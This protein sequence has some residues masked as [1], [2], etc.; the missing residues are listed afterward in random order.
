MARKEKYSIYVKPY[1]DKIVEWISEGENEYNI[2]NKL[3][4]C[5]STWHEYKIKYMEL[6]ESIKH[7]KQNL[8]LTL[9]KSLYKKAKGFEYVESRRE[10]KKGIGGYKKVSRVKKYIVPDTQALIFAL[11]NLDPENWKRIEK[12]SDIDVKF[13]DINVNLIDDDEE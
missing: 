13:P 12:D 3:G 8:L 4:I 1:L 5:E 9:R 6:M 2:A 7:G 10:V 11:T